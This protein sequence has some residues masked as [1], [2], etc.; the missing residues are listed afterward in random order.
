MYD[1]FSRTISRM[2]LL[3][4]ENKGESVETRF[5]L[6]EQAL[7]MFNENIFLG[8]GFGSFGMY[9]FGE[10]VKLYPHNLILELASETG[11]LGALIFILFVLNL[12]IKNW[13]NQLF[14]CVFVFSFLNLM[15]SYSFQDLRLFFGMLSI[16]MVLNLK[17]HDRNY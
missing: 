9:V 16:A 5:F 4:A 8:G 3:F 12:L 15:K 2:S 14:I 13:N 1:L 17:K 7:S 10:D 6:F 11:L